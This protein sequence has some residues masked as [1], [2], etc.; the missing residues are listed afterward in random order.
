MTP[1]EEKENKRKRIG[2]TQR[3]KDRKEKLKNVEEKK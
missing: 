2:N 3:K 1:S